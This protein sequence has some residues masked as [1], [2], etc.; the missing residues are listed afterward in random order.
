MVPLLPP[1]N[2]CI[3]FLSNNY[4]LNCKFYNTLQF[5]TLNKTT[6][7][8]HLFYHSPLLVPHDCIKPCYTR[9]GTQVDLEQ[10][11]DNC[12]MKKISC[13]I[14]IGIQWNQ[15]K[16]NE[17]KVQRVVI[18]GLHK[19]W[20]WN[21]FTYTN[22]SMQKYYLS[23]LRLSQIIDLAHKQGSRK[24]GTVGTCSKPIWNFCSNLS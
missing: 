19:H 10:G 8:V 20:S 4:S 17:A 22:A 12:G 18:E 21:W 16:L 2:C 6:S 7:S 23:Q 3:F 15:M 11:Q 9:C 14:A 1:G 24:M 13:N 5:K